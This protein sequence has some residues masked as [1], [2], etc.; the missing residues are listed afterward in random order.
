M[1]VAHI[2]DEW[3]PLTQIW[4][5]SSI[6]HL[7]SEVTST[8]VARRLTVDATPPP[9]EL[10]H[11]PSVAHGLAGK[12]VDV[13]APWF[14]PGRL[15]RRVKGQ[16]I[17]VLHAH[18]GAAGWDA[19]AAAALVGK[20]FV[21]SF[22]GLDV[23]AL[24][25][26]SRRWRGR[27]RRIFDDASLILALGPWM[28]SRL[29]MQGA[30]PAR[31]VVHHLGMPVG[32]LAFRPRAWE[33]DRPLR[34]LIASSFREKKGIPLAIEAL[35]SVRRRVPLDITLV[36][37]ASA[38]PREQQE[39]ERIVE[40]IV[41]EGM[42][43][44][45][46]HV[47]YVSHADL[48]A[49]ASEHDLLVAASLTARDGDTEGTPMTL[50]EL[51]AT[52]IVVVSTRHA[53]IPEIV[54]DEVTGFLAEPGDRDSFIGAIE[55]AVTRGARWPAIGAAARAHAI[56]EFDADRQGRR[57]AELYRRVSS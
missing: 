51:A 2:L 11:V 17:D 19:R 55:R 36:G 53:D 15:A 42:S 14:E 41:R 7:P 6:R 16:D 12:V 40:T 34:V 18:F 31:I 13:L 32:E 54:D 28:S 5:A 49:L 30:D 9:G 3:L 57:L 33:G 35:A 25:R 4:L 24:P 46:H 44:V 23:E 52:G 29:A 10:S 48:L 1:R 43:D 50:V 38:I 26:G 27:Y 22:Y 37:D 47:G 21:V 39:K 45:V 20:P 8:V 56:D